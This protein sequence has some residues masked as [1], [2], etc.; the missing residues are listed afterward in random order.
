V[1]SH[2][3]PHLFK[4]DK[5]DTCSDAVRGKSLFTSFERSLNT[6]FHAHP[7]LQTKSH[8]KLKD[9][10]QPKR[11]NHSV[12]SLCPSLFPYF[13]FIHPFFLCFF[14]SYFP[15]FPFCFVLRFA[16]FCSSFLLRRSSRS[17][18]SKEYLTGPSMCVRLLH[19]YKLQCITLL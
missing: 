8:G 2:A 17:K 16:L 15:C 7:S 6:S 3:N 5:G 1:N 12:L 9:A 18:A 4:T 13:C 11:E 10:E 19:C 14:S